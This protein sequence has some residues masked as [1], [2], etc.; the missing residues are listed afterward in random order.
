VK[1]GKKSLKS[2]KVKAIG[3]TL[4]PHSLEITNGL[5]HMQRT[6]IELEILADVKS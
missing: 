2:L 6:E 3:N 5:V 1:N 4:Y